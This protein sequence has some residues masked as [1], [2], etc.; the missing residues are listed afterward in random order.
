MRWTDRLDGDPLPWLLAEDTPAVRAAVLQKLF[1]RPAGDPEVAAAR[2][3]AMRS[4]P[5]RAILEAQHAEG[6]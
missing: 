5:I 1:D 4:D 6:W 2:A 3:A